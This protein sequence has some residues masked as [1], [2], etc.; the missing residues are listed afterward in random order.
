[1]WNQEIE[2]FPKVGQ[3]E[4]VEVVSFSSWL[5]FIYELSSSGISSYQI[6]VWMR[7]N[8]Y[9]EGNEY[10]NVQEE[11]LNLTFVRKKI[12]NWWLRVK[13]IR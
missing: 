2:W 3:A 4:F 8:E 7:R 10:Q 9:Y 1:M 13:F 11:K 6:I 12:Q 5:Y